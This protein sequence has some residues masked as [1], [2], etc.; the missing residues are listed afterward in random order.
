M[1]SYYLTYEK[2]APL[3]ENMCFETAAE[4]AKKWSPASWKET[5]KSG[6]RDPG[7]GRYQPWIAT[8]GY[9]CQ[10]GRRGGGPAQRDL[11]HVQQ[12]CG[13]THGL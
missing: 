3:E 1:G 6:F 7:E 5:T 8:T 2:D 11:P 9:L 10:G 4:V 12:R 13:G